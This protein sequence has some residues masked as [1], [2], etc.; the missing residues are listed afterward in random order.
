[1]PFITC[2]VIVEGSIAPPLAIAAL[3][4]FMPSMAPARGAGHLAR[5]AGADLLGVG[6]PVADLAHHR[7]GG[8]GAPYISPK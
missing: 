8:A 6:A 2:G 4:L 3:V 1:M 5:H 7:Q